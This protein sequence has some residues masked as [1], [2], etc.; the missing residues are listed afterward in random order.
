MRIFFTG[1]EIVWG[2]MTFFSMGFVP[3][4]QYPCWLQPVGQHQPISYAVAVMRALSLGGPVL[5]P[6]VTM[7][8][9]SAAIA[10]VC[11]ILMAIG[12]RRASTG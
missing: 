2:L 7:L 11:A 12:Y 1:I 3:V 5:A 4:D 10:A 8:L 9:W 6:T